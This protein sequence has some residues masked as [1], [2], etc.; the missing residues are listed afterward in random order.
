M[1]HSCRCYLPFCAVWVHQLQ[2][3]RPARHNPT[4]TCHTHSLP[5]R[6]PSPIRL[7]CHHSS[8]FWSLHSG[9]GGAYEAESPCEQ[10]PQ[11]LTTCPRIVLRQSA[12]HHTAVSESE[13]VRREAVI[14]EAVRQ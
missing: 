5:V 14:R 8:W 7:L 3:E 2:Q 1:Q 11:E 4:S 9:G 13:A 12:H 10:Q 6:Y